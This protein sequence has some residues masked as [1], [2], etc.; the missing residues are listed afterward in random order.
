MRA[1]DLSRRMSRLVRAW[2][3]SGESRRAF[4]RRHGLTV[5]QFDYWKRRVR[6]AAVAPA[7]L[8]IEVLRRAGVES[9]YTGATT[10]S[11]HAGA[12]HLHPVDTPCPASTLAL[13]K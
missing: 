5:S 12:R 13:W 7:G 3:R 2:E 6:R 1:T 8:T 4:A 9:L 11:G 10:A